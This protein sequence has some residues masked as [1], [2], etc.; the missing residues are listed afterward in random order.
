MCE[1]VPNDVA[2]ACTFPSS[3]TLTVLQTAAAATVFP[4]VYRQVFDAECPDFLQNLMVQRVEKITFAGLT[5]GRCRVQ[6]CERQRFSQ[7]CLTLL[8]GAANSVRAGSRV[9]AW[10]PPPPDDAP[11]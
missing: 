10:C 2:S 1:I 7:A 8:V 9:A 6:A 3:R 5:H 11:A 4:T